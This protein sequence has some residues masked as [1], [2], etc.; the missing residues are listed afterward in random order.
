MSVHSSTRS[1][2]QL[3]KRS[4]HILQHRGTSGILKT[5]NT[6]RDEAPSLKESS[7]V[8]DMIDK[9]CNKAVR[10]IVALVAQC[11]WDVALQAA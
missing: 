5:G 1:L 4:F 2:N 8:L 6:K 7:V 9:A 3:L 11:N 10:A